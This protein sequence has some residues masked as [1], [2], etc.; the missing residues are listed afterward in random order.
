MS[1]YVDITIIG[2]G[3]VGLAVGAAVAGLGRDIY[4]LEKNNSFG[5]ETSSRNSQVIHSDGGG[6]FNFKTRILINC[7]GLYAQEIAEMAGI[8]TIK[9]GYKVYYCKG[10]YFKVADSKSKMVTRLVYPVPPIGLTGVG[11]H[12]T[13]DFDGRMRLGP[14]VKYIDTIDYSV[15]E[16]KKM[17]FYEN[18]KRFLP[19][20][21][22]EDL[23]PEMAGIR[24]KL[25]G[26]GQ[27]QR[28]FIISHEKE[29]DLAGLINLIGIES[30]GLTASPAIADLVRNIVRKIN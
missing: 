21:S 8:D 7:A 14:G 26:P 17:L 19:F 1:K 22:E 27:K 16:S 25:Q 30:P 15:D 9:S 12:V 13:I 3:V 24:P 6:N 5:L 29:K 11:I 20:L 2:S 18:V 4:L 10:E 28:D 23:T